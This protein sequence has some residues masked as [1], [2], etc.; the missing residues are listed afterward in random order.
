MDIDGFINASPEVLAEYLTNLSGVAVVVLDRE[1]VIQDCNA[2]FVKMLGL[3]G[4]PVYR[5]FDEFVG[6][7]IGQ[8]EVFPPT[9]AVV[10][11]PVVLKYGGRAVFVNGHVF[12][13]A[14]G[15]VIFCE[16]AAQAAPDARIA[17]LTRELEEKT[18]ELEKANAAINRVM[19]TDPLTGLA[20]RKYFM[21]TLD[22][23]ISF[24]RRSDLPLSL[25]M[26]DMDSFKFIIETYGHDKADEILVLFAGVM[27]SH[28]RSE[29]VVARV[30]NDEFMI[31]LQNTPPERALLC[32]ERIFETFR[33]MRV[34][35]VAAN[36][37]AS[38]G[39]VSLR[40]GDEADSVVAR[41]DDALFKA[42]G[43]GPVRVA[44]I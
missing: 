7:E 44:M 8:N 17:V 41:A 38:F 6:A 19:E 5:K 13:V 4:K 30:G 21:D 33:G 3:T 27:N 40:D 32:A 42:K 39:V 16:R 15:S 1:R 9:G 24:A 20:N 29:D 26:C 34:S 12:P 28:T 31:L 25:I 36:I 37:S 10:D 22:R 14:D 35:G 11:V 18:A 43:S 23:T 2:G